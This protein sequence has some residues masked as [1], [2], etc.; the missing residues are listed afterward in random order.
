MSNSSETGSCKKCTTKISLEAERCPQCGYEPGKAVLGPIGKIIGFILLIGAGFQLLVGLLLLLIP[1]TGAPISSAL[2]GAGIFVT[3][4]LVQAAIAN[5]IGKF[6][7]HYA[8]EQPEE[9][10]DDEPSK[11]FKEEMQE[12]YERG[13]EI[14]DQW[15][16]RIDKL[17]ASVFSAV[18]IAGCLFVFSMFAVAGMETEIAGMSTEDLITVLLIVTIAIFPFTVLT[19][20]ARVNRIYDTNYNW[21]VWA[22]PSMIPVVGFIP[23]LGWLWRRRSAEY[24]EQDMETSG[25]T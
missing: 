14:G 3:A 22:P 1:I 11:S 9:T 8:A 12:S 16:E 25:D 4:G 19:D 20:I 17:P 5:W 23:A 7:T 2:L 18:M 6:G 10:S 24:P 13:E 21:W 15:R